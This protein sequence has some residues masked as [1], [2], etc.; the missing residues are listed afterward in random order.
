MVE[1]RNKYIDRAIKLPKNGNRLIN[2]GI[3]T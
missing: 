1:V 3:S 2:T